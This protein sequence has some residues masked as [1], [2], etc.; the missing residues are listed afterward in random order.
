GDV[1]GV[2]RWAE[3][4]AV[5]GR[6]LGVRQPLGQPAHLLASF[7]REVH[8]DRAREAVFGGELRRAV[9]DEIEAGDGGGHDRPQADARESSSAAP[10]GVGDGASALCGARLR[11]EPA[12]WARRPRCLNTG[13]C[14]SRK[15]P[16]IAFAL[17]PRRT[18]GGSSFSFLVWPPPSIT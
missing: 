13:A 15:P 10:S 1:G 8:A 6:A 11:R 3:G 9:A 7:V 14:H 12:T 16:S 4:A 5:D 2:G 17:L 18:P